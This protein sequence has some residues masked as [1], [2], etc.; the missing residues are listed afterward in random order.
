MDASE[1]TRGSKDTRVQ[2]RLHQVE[3]AARANCGCPSDTPLLTCLDVVCLTQFL[4]G[5][6]C[7][8]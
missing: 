3:G 1:R 4:G 5:F 7:D 2:Q 8:A 6:R